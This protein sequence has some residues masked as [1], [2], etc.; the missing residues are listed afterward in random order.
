MHKRRDSFLE[1]LLNEFER[2][3]IHSSPTNIAEDKKNASI[4]EALLSI[5][6]AETEQYSDEIIKGIILL[7]RVRCKI[8]SSQITVAQDMA[9]FVNG[10][11]YKDPNLA[12]GTY[13]F[14][15]IL[16]LPG[17]ISNFI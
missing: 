14:Y 5:Q 17:N 2:K 3:Q 11:A 4:I 10:F 9:A 6:E 13:F 16:H 12:D 8:Y 15:S 1:N 7:N